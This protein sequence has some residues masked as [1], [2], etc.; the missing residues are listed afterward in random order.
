MVEYS[1][2][3]VLIQSVTHPFWTITSD[4]QKDT[5]CRK[6]C[7]SKCDRILSVNYQGPNEYLIFGNLQTKEQ[8]INENLVVCT[9]SEEMFLQSNFEDSIMN[10]QN[11][12]PKLL[13]L[14]SVDNNC[15]L[16]PTIRSYNL[17]NS[18]KKGS[19]LIIHGSKDGFIYIY[20]ACPLTQKVSNLSQSSESLQFRVKKVG[21]YFCGKFNGSEII[22]CVFVHNLG[23]GLLSDDAAPAHTGNDTVATSQVDIL[24]GME[25]LGYIIAGN[26]NGHLFLLKVLKFL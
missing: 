11:I 21:Q 1:F 20:E 24:S 22:S 18:N 14:L 7:Y 10:T 6:F 4:L 16:S 2:D 19:K 13:Q 5:V 23:G 26:K 25:I 8:R 9:T 12:H 15:V 3:M 17:E